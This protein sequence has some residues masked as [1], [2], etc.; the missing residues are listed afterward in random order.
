MEKKI[1]GKMQEKKWQKLKIDSSVVSTI[2]ALV[3]LLVFF[4]IVVG[5]RFWKIDNVI[6]IAANASTVGILACGMA[7]VIIMGGL[8][9]SIAANASFAA[10]MMGI[11][12]V[13]VGA[14]SIV[15]MLV[16]IACSCVLGLGNGILIAKFRLNPM[17]A[18]LSTQLIIRAM[19]YIVNNSLSL[20]IDTPF[21]KAFGRTMIFGRIPIYIL[22]FILTFIVIGYV[23]RSTIFGRKI[24]AIGGNEQAAY[25]SGI[26]IQKN[27]IVVYVLCGLLAGIAGI[28]NAISN[29]NAM[30][31]S[32]TGR[33]FDVIAAVV[34]GGV[35]LSGGKGTMIGTFLGVLVLTVIGNGLV[36][37]GVQSYWQTFVQGFILI[38][39]V[40][41]DA[42]R[43]RDK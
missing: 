31:Q 13:N 42:T 38:L 16:G 29:R 17:I 7:M 40:L 2:I 34:L 12:L 36:L 1:T 22:Y 41:I 14:P 4:T 35:S 10:M 26:S 23:L 5:E 3:A 25:L 6:T 43:N 30:P 33:E 21:L 19:C 27:K 9:L 24:Y 15:A 11:M 28:I 39:A 32:F 8:D 37:F 20:T 18:T